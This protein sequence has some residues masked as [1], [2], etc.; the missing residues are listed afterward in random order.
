MAPSKRVENAIRTKWAND[1]ANQT[2][3]SHA[4][5]DPNNLT[6][7]WNQ[8]KKLDRK[9]KYLGESK[10]VF[11][12]HYKDKYSKPFLPPIWAMTEV[13]SFT[14]ST[15]WLDNTKSV[16]IKISIARHLEFRS[17]DIF[18]GALHSIG[19]IRNICA[20]HSRLWNLRMVKKLPNIR[21]LDGHLQ[22]HPNNQV[23]NYIYN[24]LVV[25]L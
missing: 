5:M 13:L 24:Y 7:P 17:I 8:K 3:N 9:N 21:A 6:C 19:Y 1:I 25:I 14:D 11:V 22:K 20:H 4:F 12:P 2:K 16:D 18:K 23:N 10:E 15:L